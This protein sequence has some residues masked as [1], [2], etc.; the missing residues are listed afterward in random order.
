MNLVMKIKPSDGQHIFCLE[1][2]KLFRMDIQIHENSILK[3]QKSVIVQI[4][5]RLIQNQHFDIL[6]DQVF[7]NCQKASF[8]VFRFKIIKYGR[9]RIFISEQKTEQFL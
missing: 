8:Y 4:R 5:R 1:I 6:I 3:K 7:R 2:S 9:Y